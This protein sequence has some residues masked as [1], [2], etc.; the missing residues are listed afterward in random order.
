MTAPLK[1]LHKR[2]APQGLPAN[3][4]SSVRPISR[5]AGKAA[6]LERVPP[7]GKTASWRGAL[8]ALGYQAPVVA[9][10][11]PGRQEPR[12]RGFGRG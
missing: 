8:A 12:E 2:D 10:E 7:S 9:P 6:T 5:G 4:P 11:A 1:D 3:T